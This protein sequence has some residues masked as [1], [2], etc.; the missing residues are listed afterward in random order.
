MMETD[1]IKPMDIDVLIAGGGVAGCAAAAALSSLGLRILVIEPKASQGRRL[2]G[3]LIHPPGIDG[4]KQLGLLSDTPEIG[5]RIRGFSIHPF[6]PGA[7]YKDHIVLPYSEVDG[8]DHGGMAIEHQA[9]KD[10]LLKKIQSFNGVTVWMGARVTDICRDD[11][12]PAHFFALINHQQQLIRIDAKLIIGADGPMS[13]VRKLAGIPHETHRYSGMLGVEVDD[14]HL[15]TAQHGNIF[16]NPLGISYAY[17][18]AKGRARV[19]FEILR[20]DD[21]KESVREHL[22]SFPAAFRQD[23]EQA[24]A[25]E[26][27]LAAANYRIIPKTS[28]LKNVALLGDARGCCHPLTASGITT[29]V[30]DALSL[31]DALQVHHLD[32]P[33]ALRDYA[34]AVGRIQLTRRTLSEELR[35]AFLSHTQESDLL[36]RCIFEYWRTNPRGRA[37]SLALLSTLDSSIL[38][39]GLQFIMVVFQAFRLLPAVI[40]QGELWN[41]TLSMMKLAKKSLSIPQTALQHWFREQ[42]ALAK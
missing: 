21:S 18:V 24:M 3:E 33:A 7:E 4:L 9:L 36:N 16:L 35:E 34:L 27:P 8:L 40:R 15:P 26:K 1:S 2:A 41:W 5:S 11:V 30:K 14:R 19:M 31:R 12:R 23:I 6:K 37:H 20:G 32:F 29:A 38:S 13:Q 17:S 25:N 10:H 42:K 22:R 39:M 28:V